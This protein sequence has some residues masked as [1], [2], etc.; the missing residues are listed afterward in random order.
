MELTEDE[1]RGIHELAGRLKAECGALE[2]H[3]FGSAA[4]GD[5]DPESDI[6][7]MVML[8]EFCPDIEEAVSD[9]CFEA[10]LQIRRCICC[11]Y[12][13]QHQLTETPL[14]ASPL[15]LNIQREGVRL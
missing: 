5:M 13:T 9:R 15:V 10:G 2:V 11:L 1:H 4:R 12:L 3:L 6:D 14:R 7:L 8:P